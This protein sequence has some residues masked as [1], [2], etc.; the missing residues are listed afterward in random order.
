ME[1]DGL[2]PAQRARNLA[3][4]FAKRAA[5]HDRDATFPYEN[6]EALKQAN[7]L[8]LTVPAEHGG[9]DSGLAETCE[10]LSA[11]AEGDASTALVLAMHYLMH[12]TIAR[13]AQWPVHILARLARGAVS[14]GELVNA[15]RVEPELGTPARGGMPATIAEEVAHGWR[16]S[17]HKIYSTGMPL[18][19][20]L[21]V[22]AR[23]AEAQPRVGTFLVPAHASGV[24]T[25]ETWDHLGM[26]A[27]ASHD[28]M[29]ESVLVPRDYAV[30]I[31]EPSEWE[32]TRRRASCVVRTR[33]I[34][35][36]QRRRQSGA[37]LARDLSD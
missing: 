24:R 25:V 27:S 15:L 18:L 13:S 10:V 31:R 11:V 23:T 26:R 17:G 4:D 9:L 5:G 14:N 35:L 7:L 2:K 37:R 8:A 22:W 20:W 3:R 29:F 19:S 32:G 30:D 33:F 16:I 1:H 21:M 12:A 28:V 6:F 34:G 36:V